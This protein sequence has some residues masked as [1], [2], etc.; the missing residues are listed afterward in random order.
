MKS[1]FLVGKFLPG[2][3]STFGKMPNTR[4][5]KGAI[6]KDQLARSFEARA[7]RY[8]QRRLEYLIFAQIGMVAALSLTIGAFNLEIGT[9]SSASFA[10]PDQEIVQMEDI[11]QTAQMQK[12]PPPPRPPV[13]VAVPDDTRLEDVELDLD[14]FLDLDEVV[15]DLPPPPPTPAGDIE[16]EIFLVVEQMPVIIGGLSKLYDYVK[17]PLIAKK[18]GIEGT[19]VIKLV[20]T[21]Q[22]EPSRGEIIK[23]VHDLLDQAAL[24]GVMKLTFEPARQRSRAVP[25][26]ISIP[27]KFDLK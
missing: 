26:W 22:G 21:A 12:P 9:G 6:H 17:Y 2:Y 10:L 27:I 19:V 16:E 5:R 3:G 11:I 24:E 4:L 15:V 25:V 20:V 8:Q 18:A 1:S 23:S 7:T 13:P 14:A